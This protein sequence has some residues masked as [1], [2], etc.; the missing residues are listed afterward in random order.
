MT[1]YEILIKYPN[2]DEWHSYF[3]RHNWMSLAALAMADA[4]RQFPKNQ[5]K[6]K[7]VKEGDLWHSPSGKSTYPSGDR[8]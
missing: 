1:M 8:S 6:L 3:S 2:K 7:T 5:F 4:Q